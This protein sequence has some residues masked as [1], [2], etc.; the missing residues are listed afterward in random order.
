[1]HGSRSARR[2]VRAAFAACLLLAPL[3]AG[4]TPA[5][6]AERIA[7]GIRIAPVPLNLSGLDRN[8]VGLGS[9]L[10]NAVAGCNDCHSLQQFA[11]GGDPYLG[12]KKKINQTDYLAGGR[13]FGPFVSPNVTPD[14]R[15][16]PAGLT[17]ARFVQV[18]RTGVDP[19][20]S[21]RLLQVM[22]WPAYQDMQYGDLK[23]IYAYLQ[24]VPSRPSH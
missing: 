23:A 6:N 20:D 9:Y 10:V 17:L 16:R 4:A 13:A 22:P 19:D 7:K 21:S 11:P 3:A 15:R 12:Q 18:M 2:I 5:T 14:A 1:M 24:A 8:L